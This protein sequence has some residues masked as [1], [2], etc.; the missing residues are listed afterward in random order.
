[1]GQ[2]ILQAF[3]DGSSLRAIAAAAGMSHEKVRIIIATE[4][5]RQRP[6]L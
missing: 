3:E 1:M 4:R 6:P 5:K 2:V